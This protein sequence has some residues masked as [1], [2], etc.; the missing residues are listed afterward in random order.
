[1]KPKNLFVASALALTMSLAPISALSSNWALH[2][3]ETQE[4][5]AAS[6]S[7]TIEGTAEHKGVKYEIYQIFTGTKTADSK[8][9][10]SIEW[11]SSASDVLQAA[12]KNHFGLA[13]DATAQDVA[14]KIAGE[15]VSAEA[16][17][18][19]IAANL[20]TKVGEATANDNGTAVF[21]GLA[22]GYYFV[23]NAADEGNTPITDF[24]LSVVGPTTAHP[25]TSGQPDQEKKVIENH[26]DKTGS[27]AVLGDG[28]KKNDAADY[29][30]GDN[31]PFEIGAKVPA[32][33]E[34]YTSYKFTLHDKM[35]AGLTLNPESIVVKAAGVALDPSAYTLSTN[36]SDGDTCDIEI[37]I[38]AEGGDQKWAAGT[39]IT[40]EFTARLNEN[41]KLNEAG[42]ENAFKLSFS[43]NPNGEGE[44]ES[45]WDEVV[46]FTYDM[47]LNKTDNNKENPKELYG[48]KFKLFREVNGSKEW[49][50]AEGA[51][52]QYTVKAWVS[53]ENAAT[54]LSA[55]ANTNS[56]YIKGL[57]DGAYK[58]KE[59]AAPD[60]YKLPTEPFDLT[61]KAATV[62]DQNY[63]GTPSA[64]IG[65][66]TLNGTTGNSTNIENTQGNALP[67][68]GGM[69]TTTLYVTGAI[70]AGGAA[71]L[72]VTNKRMKKEN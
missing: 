55:A 17:A 47:T 19:I 16:V 24:I 38:K 60:G 56:Y 49:L 65:D 41:A 59:T 68:T 29:N 58:L 66:I 22:N 9:L 18:D 2:A 5:P 71:L 1:M 63:A 54:E 27:P 23:K 6:A 31:V 67:E 39:L 57:D 3:E 15:G 42:N 10:G 12:L 20:G 46:V 14:E 8:V 45:T 52:G 33:I 48:A 44:G 28:D 26:K 13:A 36:P 4:T 72:L 35:D 34:H 7:L 50:Q 30:I 43:N 64:A 70:L 40:A 51:D 62:N 69:G 32:G 61:L 53:D 11:G 37:Q 25:K 21:T